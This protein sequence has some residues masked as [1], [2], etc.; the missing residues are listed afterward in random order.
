MNAWKYLSII[1]IKAE[2]KSAF[3]KEA[4]KLFTSDMRKSEMVN[5]SV[6][7]IFLNTLYELWF[8]LLLGMF[9]LSSAIYLLCV[10]DPRKSSCM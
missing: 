8:I 3:K 7:Y 6:F 2:Q 10:F 9:N 4:E 1:L 5:Y